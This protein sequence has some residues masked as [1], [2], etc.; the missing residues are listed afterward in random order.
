[1]GTSACGHAVAMT[2]KT[3]RAWASGGVERRR[4]HMVTEYKKME[5]AAAAAVARRLVGRAVAA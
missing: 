1:M 5:R 2:Y 4:P 3:K